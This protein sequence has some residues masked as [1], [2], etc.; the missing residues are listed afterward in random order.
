MPDTVLTV[1][2]AGS[3]HAWNYPLPG[4]PLG[5]VTSVLVAQA[6]S[7]RHFVTFSLTCCHQFSEENFWAVRGE[8][9]YLKSHSRDICP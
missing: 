3:N 8:M 6:M 2:R 5:E 1:A 7:G 4:C 9:N